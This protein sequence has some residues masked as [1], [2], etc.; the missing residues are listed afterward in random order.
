[1]AKAIT[2]DRKAAVLGGKLVL[3]T[4]G[5]PCCCGGGGGCP[6]CDDPVNPNDD[7]CGPFQV[8]ISYYRGSSWPT[9]TAVR[10]KVRRFGNVTIDYN[11]DGG[12]GFGDFDYDDT[13]DTM[14]LSSGCSMSTPVANRLVF[15]YQH[16]YADRDWA[17]TVEVGRH[18]GSTAVVPAPI[19]RFVQTPFPWGFW[20]FG[21]MRVDVSS[22]PFRMGHSA[23]AGITHAVA[24]E[25]Q[26]AEV[27]F[28][29]GDQ[30]GNSEVQPED[31]DTY[32][33]TANIGGRAFGAAVCS[34]TA[35]FEANMRHDDPA[36]GYMSYTLRHQVEASAS[37]LISRSG[38]TELAIGNGRCGGLAQDDPS[39]AGDPIIIGGQVSGY[40]D[41]RVQAML[42]LQARGG[43][44]RGCNE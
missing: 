26:S 1:M 14:I 35:C 31:I 8:P 30:F 44:C 2:I 37:C 27:R 19:S 4:N 22:L 13:L 9:T 34:V 36:F 28:S 3:D 21:G 16:R 5:A 20:T 23:A 11:W 12:V 29:A 39:D 41:P 40:L 17:S 18:F 25:V 33:T 32:T 38:S 7:A 24:P 6:T 15:P 43:G 42:D 10:Y